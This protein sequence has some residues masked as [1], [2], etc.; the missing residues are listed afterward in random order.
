MGA[1][2][3][4]RSS[5]GTGASRGAGSDADMPEFVTR[6]VYQLAP[7]LVASGR[8]G[9]RMVGQHICHS[10]WFVA[11]DMPADKVAPARLECQSRAV[12]EQGLLN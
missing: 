2:W 10:I 12:V 1:Y 3:R 9:N 4:E 7:G 5:I 6:V 11:Q 8:A